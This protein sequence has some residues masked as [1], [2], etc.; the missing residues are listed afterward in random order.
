MSFTVAL[1]RGYAQLLADSGVGVYSTSGVY[2]ADKVG[3]FL[4][5][6]PDQPDRAIT[7]MVYPVEETDLTTVTMGLQLRFRGDR[8]TSTVEDMADAVFDLLHNREHYTVGGV[9]VPLSW[10][11]SAAWLGQDAN[12]RVER[13]ENYYLHAE[14]VAPHLRP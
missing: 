9:K 10:R 7:L 6:T 1:T 5:T 3:I 14:R 2:P 13:S 8:N 11:Q 12:R 4:G